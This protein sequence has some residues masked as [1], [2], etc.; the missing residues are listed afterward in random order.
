MKTQKVVIIAAIMAMPVTAFLSHAGA[1]PNKMILAGA[2]SNLAITRI[3][4]DAFIKKYPDIS[5][6]IPE[7]I[8]SSGGISAVS[9]GAITV[10]LSSRPFREN[11]KQLG[12]ELAPYARTII[13]MGAHP[14]VPD[15]NITY[16]EIIQI[17]RGKKT[18]WK[19]GKDIIVLTRNEGE[20]TIDV[21][22]QLIP[23]F[24]EAHVE[25]LQARRWITAFTDQDMN[26][27][28]T[29]MPD[30]V[31][32][33]DYGTI[34]SEHLAIKMLKVDGIAPTAENVLKGRYALFKTLYF[35][36]RRDNIQPEAKAFIDFVRS[37]EGRKILKANGYL[38]AEKK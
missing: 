15:D 2:G 9:E 17:Y 23:G 35:V 6:Q 29:T 26:K 1:E 28:L 18:T 24:R 16:E 21:M 14:G 3:L 34:A 12:L 31:G 8:G 22:K 10:G 11:E 25:S 30:S 5:I 27:K 13:I 4:A 32:M 38:L 33:S 36:F 7:S 19:N 20:S 37:T